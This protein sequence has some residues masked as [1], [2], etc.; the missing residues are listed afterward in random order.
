MNS[1]NDF[2]PGYCNHIYQQFMFALPINIKIL[3]IEMFIGK[4]NVNICYYDPNQACN[5]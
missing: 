1:L 5:T 2:Y 3:I 4:K